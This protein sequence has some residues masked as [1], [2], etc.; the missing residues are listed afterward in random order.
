MTLL[1]LLKI[2]IKKAGWNLLILVLIP[3]IGLA[4]LSDR[5][6]SPATGIFVTLYCLFG[7]IIVAIIPFAAENAE[8]AGFLEML[9]V[10]PGLSVT[11][12]F[13]FSALCVLISGGLGALAGSAVNAA[14]RSASALYPDGM[15]LSSLYFSAF[16]AALLFTAIDCLLLTICRYNTLQ[17]LQ[18]IR[19]L[20]A[21]VFFF[22]STALLQNMET[23]STIFRI[24]N[25]NGLLIFILCA[26]SFAA[27]A[28]V[29]REITVRGGK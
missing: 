29:S 17:V 2:D 11:S 13:T 25:E 27:L 15:N 21:F 20:P 1:K 12:H 4:V 8:E 7:G 22:G 3:L 28:A 18:I 14:G 24:L 6:I 5:D 19:I 23:T 26:L 10:K 9:P 16:G